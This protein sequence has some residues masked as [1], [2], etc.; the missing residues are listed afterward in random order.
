MK[1]HEVVTADGEI[2]IDENYAD[3]YRRYTHTFIPNDELKVPPLYEGFSRVPASLTVPGVPIFVRFIEVARWGLFQPETYKL[4][5]VYRYK[6]AELR[7]TLGLESASAY[8]VVQVGVFHT[9]EF[10]ETPNTPCLVKRRDGVEIGVSLPTNE[11]ARFLG[12]DTFFLTSDVSAFGDKLNSETNVLAFINGE[13]KIVHGRVY[14]FVSA[15]FL[16]NVIIAPLVSSINPSFIASLFEEP[17]AE[18]IPEPP[19]TAMITG[20]SSGTISVRFEKQVAY[21]KF[22][23]SFGKHEYFLMFK[24]GWIYRGVTKPGDS[25]GPLFRIV[26]R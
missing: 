10:Y 22:L 24:Y 20:S 7:G 23:M 2:W 26:S 18:S 11:P 15:S 14:G 5:N 12:K 8:H 21:Y 6:S 17:F 3:K 1:L 4:D 19:E 16:N 9:N 25:G 13:P